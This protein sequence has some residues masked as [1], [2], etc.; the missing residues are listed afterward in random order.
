MTTPIASFSGIASGIQWRD[1]IDQIMDI[2]ARRRYEPVA[3]RQS[4]LRT[5]AEAWR[6]F[7]GVASKLRDATKALQAPGA[8][9]LYRT[10]ITRPASSREFFGATASS[11]A[12]PGSYNVEVLAT[13][14]AEKLGGAVAATATTALGVSGQ[15]AVNGRGITVTAD[16]TLNSLRDKINA[17]SAGAGAD[18]VS[19]TVLAT[20]GGMRLV[21]TA[22][23]SGA[24]G[25]D[26]TDDAAGTLAA[27]GFTDGTITANIGSDGAARTQRVSSSTA[28]IA[29]VLGVPMPTPSTIRIGGQAITVDLN[30]DSLTTIANKIAI[31]T[32][33][34]DAAR[35]RSEKVGATTRYWLETDATVDVDA[36]DAANSARTL[37]TLGFTKGGRGDVTQVVASA[38]TFVD[39][40]TGLNATGTTLLS[41]LQVN[42]QSLALG[43]GDVVTIGGTRGDGTTVSR[44][45]TLG[46]GST[47]QDLLAAI[48]DNGT[49]F[50]AGARTASADVSDGRLR[51]TDAAAGDSA[52]G[53][54]LT[55]ARNSGGTVSL[56]AFG[57]AQGTVGRD[58]VLTAGTDAVLRLD[59]Q[60]LRRSTN[61]I[62]DAIG[63]VTLTAYAAEVGTTATLEVQRDADGAVKLLQDFATQYNALRSWVATNGGEGGALANNGALRAMAASLTSQLLAPV[64]GLVGSYTVASLAGLEHDKNGVLALN[65][66]A[67]K[68]AFAADFT[69]VSKLFSE[70]G[71]V[72]DSEV[73]F[74]AA[75]GKAAPTATG[76]AI[77]ITRAATQ[78]A[79]TGAVLA[80]YATTG[81]P[82]TMRVTDA[83]TGRTVDITMSDGESLTAI[84]QR[85]NSA[86]VV[87]GL[88]LTAEVTV[89]SRL[90]ITSTEYGSE[91]GFTVAYTPGTGGD[92]TAALGIA[93]G[94]VAGLDVAG[95]IN[96]VVASGSG[97]ILTGG[98]G[99]GTDAA[100]GVIIRYRGTTARAA[101]TVAFSLGMAG[102]L[103]RAVQT[104]AADSSGAALN[105]ASATTQA[106]ALDPRLDDI[107]K[108]LDARREALI[109]QFVAMEGALAKS[110]ALGAALTSQLNALSAQNSR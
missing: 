93:A 95:T 110:Q 101:G 99:G 55:V 58:R 31:A 66:G 4:A 69:A 83:A 103:L 87:D 89:D 26:L 48:G 35:V 20:S 109:R 81:T 7:Q 96:G 105:A 61:T 14:Q 18:G 3:S 75:G 28:A 43:A 100:E 50:G 45:F 107:Q 79:I 12:T 10:S 11:T 44:T 86:F 97:Q 90:R 98:N 19:A 42:G 6:A 85:L 23:S 22:S 24:A 88:R 60:L 54:S 9:N 67:F 30:T 46:A 16:D 33:N 32:G 47:V 74:I 91:G 51:L 27:L 106:D 70:S 92:G 21:I 34:A 77:A 71:A 38:N 15:F 63:G 104:M 73:E 72:T 17:A 40:L 52:L 102:T 56:G 29:S 36:G 64:T 13:A 57:T 2:E 49:G 59:G 68:T 78:A 41:D 82:D 62:T 5:Q 8:F 39:A 84:A 25:I 53:F 94:T 108:R 37:A 65:A 1:M 80:S 76:Y